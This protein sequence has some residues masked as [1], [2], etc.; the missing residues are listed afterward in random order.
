MTQQYEHTFLYFLLIYIVNIT[1]NDEYILLYFVVEIR[2][3]RVSNTNFLVYQF[4]P[5]INLNK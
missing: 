5:K 4:Q 2:I 1:Y 3:S